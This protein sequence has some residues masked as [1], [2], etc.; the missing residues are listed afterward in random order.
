MLKF[1]R[2]RKLAARLLIWTGFLA[3]VFVGASTFFAFKLTGPRSRAIA[4][5]P[6]DFPF[7]VERVSWT[8]TD[9]E[10]ITGWFVPGDGADKAIVL[11][12]GFGGDRRQLLPRAKFF[13]QQ[14]YAVLLYD[15]RAC[16]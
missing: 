5:P 11:L 12:H 8:T 9:V 16:G 3:V 7:P 6:D 13:R 4:G 1:L 14:G 10:A 2:P 15:A